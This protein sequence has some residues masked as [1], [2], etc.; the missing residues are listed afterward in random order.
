MEEAVVDMPAEPAAPALLARVAAGD[1]AAMR[2]CL[3][4]YARL[5]WSIA[6]RF[7]VGDAEDAVQEIFLEVWKSAARYDAALGTEAVFVATIARRRLID[8]RRTRA[9][10]PTTEA[11]EVDGEIAMATAGAGGG[12]ERSAE[13]QQAARALAKLRPEQQRV[14]VMA[15]CHGMSHGEIAEETGMPL[16]TVKAHARRGLLSIRSALLGVPE[17]ERA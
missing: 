3:Q 15:A 13:A 1:R 9:R 17:E 6:R 8:R 5:V 11:I 14:L 12:P 10:R 7:E 2:D 16:G 4:Q